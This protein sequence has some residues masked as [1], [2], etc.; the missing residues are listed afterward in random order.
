MPAQKGP[1][2]FEELKRALEEIDAQGVVDDDETEEDRRWM[3]ALRNAVAA[4]PTSFGSLTDEEID[5]IADSTSIV[6]LNPARLA[7]LKDRGKREQARAQ[8]LTAHWSKA[9]P[10][11]LATAAI[12]RQDGEA[13]P[14]EQRVARDALDE[15]R[16][17]LDE[18]DGPKS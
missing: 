2:P 13:N 8:A 14:E 15:V 7:R 5:A 16:R 12:F 11:K 1:N 6:S 4:D 18:E 9:S 17:Q 10:G 3:T